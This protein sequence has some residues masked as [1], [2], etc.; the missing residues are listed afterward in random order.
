MGPERIVDFEGYISL[1][2]TKYPELGEVFPAEETL[3][4]RQVKDRTAR[5]H[6]IGEFTGGGRGREWLKGAGSQFDI[7]GD[8]ARK[9]LD[10]ILNEDPAW[11][12][13]SDG[14]VRVLDV[15]GGAG[16]L[17]KFL[18]ERTNFDG[19]AINSDPSPL[20]VAEGLNADVPTLWQC[21]QDLFLTDD[22]S[23]DAVVLAYG[24]HHVPPDERREMFRE[25]ARVLRPGGLLLFHDY[26]NNSRTDKWFRDVVHPYTVTG[27]DHRH[28]T[29]NG[30][31]EHLSSTGF[32]VE[33]IDRAT[34]YWD[35][36]K[37]SF[38]SVREHC[39]AYLSE[40]YGIKEPEDHPEF[41]EFL[42]HHIRSTFDLDLRPSVD[43]HG[44]ASDYGLRVGRPCILATAQVTETA[45]SRG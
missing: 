5:L 23:M 19:Y 39:I 10:P 16:F 33:E 44:E 13:Q 15:F 38:E 11:R 9:V 8:S 45:D 14:P 2:R 17:A 35:F 7:R 12:R 27:H 3:D 43:A 20:M 36:N 29:V 6:E 34:I 37:Q 30:L 31:V 42:W 24:V 21:A 25:A 40:A 41:D 22:D 4:P 26:L 28:F 1:L 18:R 32:R